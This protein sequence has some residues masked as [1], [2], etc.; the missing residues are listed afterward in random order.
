MRG[1]V[2][3]G[4]VVIKCDY[5]DSHGIADGRHR[6]NDRVVARDRH[7]L[8]HGLRN[9]AGRKRNHC[10]FHRIDERAPLKHRFDLGFRNVRK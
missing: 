9:F 10:A 1:Q 4:V 2:R 6:S 8:A 7:H 5:F 3:A